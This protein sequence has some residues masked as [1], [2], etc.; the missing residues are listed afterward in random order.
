MG[1]G[2]PN[3]LV[4]C[5]YLLMVFFFIKPHYFPCILPNVWWLDT[6]CAVFFLLHEIRNISIS[7]FIASI[8]HEKLDCLYLTKCWVSPPGSFIYL[9]T[10]PYF[11]VADF[12]FNY[13]FLVKFVIFRFRDSLLTT[14]PKNWISYNWKG[15]R[16]MLG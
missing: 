12:F 7:W 15:G 3:I 13:F 5:G 16:L 6:K 4:S 11:Y 8:F 2:I 9:M 14:C 10:F 1:L